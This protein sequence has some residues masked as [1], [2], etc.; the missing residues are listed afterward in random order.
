MA[1]EMFWAIAVMI[2]GGLMAFDYVKLG[3]IVLFFA[4]LLALVT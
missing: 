3:G 4:G 2:A 1:I